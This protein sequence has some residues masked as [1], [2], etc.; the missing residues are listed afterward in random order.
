[1][2]HAVTFEQLNQWREA[3]ENDPQRQLA[4][5]ALSKSE[6]GSAAYSQG[7]A[8]RMH[9]RCSVEVETLPVTNQKSSGR[10]WLFAATDVVREAI[11]K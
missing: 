9:P 6:I 10:C 2:N 5:L 8:N 4:A 1:M 3:W 11:A 7:A